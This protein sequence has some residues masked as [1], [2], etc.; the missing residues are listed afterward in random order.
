MNTTDLENFEEKAESHRKSW[1]EM[2]DNLYRDLS[3]VFDKE[4][5]LVFIEINEKMKETKHALISMMSGGI[6]LFV[7]GLCFAATAIIGLNYV[8]ELWVA[9][10]VVTAVCLIVGYVLFKGAQKRLEVD[11]LK[12]HHSMDALSEMKNTFKERYHDFKLQ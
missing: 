8:T 12:P 1:K 11:K 6:L 2:G 7:G 9:A 3:D 10:S 5:R 4:K